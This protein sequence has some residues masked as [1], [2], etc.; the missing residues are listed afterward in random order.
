MGFVSEMRGASLTFFE[1]SSKATIATS[2]S[3]LADAQLVKQGMNYW[4]CMN[5]A[6]ED[7]AGGNLTRLQL[8][9]DQ[10]S[11]AGVNHLRIMAATQGS[12]SRQ[13][14]RILPALQTGPL[15]WDERL[16]AGLD[17]CISEAGKRGMRVTMVM[18]NTWQWTGGN[19]QLHA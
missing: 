7:N 3:N 18:G 19:A 2:S 13:P 17:K 6:A 14:Y 1:V 4:S 8:E 15:R 5:L 16:F 11:V 9:L 10:L 12:E